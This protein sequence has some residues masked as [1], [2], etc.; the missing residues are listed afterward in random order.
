MQLKQTNTG[1]TII[2]ALCTILVISLIAAGVLMNSSARYNV[3]SKQVKG[4]KEA[5]YA[6][7]SGG[8]IAFAEVRKVLSSPGTAFSGWT[9]PASPAPTPGP[10]YGKGPYTFG[11]SNSLSTSV[12][13]DMFYTDSA[14]AKYY[15]IRSTGTAKLF[16]LPRT[17][18]DSAL[19]A[20]G[21]HF[22]ANSNTRGNGDTLL[23]K[24]DF[25]YDHFKATY[26]DG[27]GTN[28]AMQ[29]VSNPQ[30]TRR[31]EL[32]VGPQFAFTGALKATGTFAG[33]GSAGVVDSYDS[34]NGAYSFVANNPASPL[35][36]DSQNGDV[37]VGTSNFNQG[38]PIYGNV[39]TNGGNVTHANSTV[40]G[41]IDNNAP[42]TIPP[43]V[44]PDT[45]GYTSGAGGTLTLPAPT[46]ANGLVGTT[47]GNPA[48]YYYS[49]L[50]GGLTINGRTVPAG[51]GALSGKPVETWVKIVVGAAGAT[52]GDVGDITIAPGINVQIYYTG[53]FSSKGKDTNN[54]N[55]D[56]ATGVYT[57]AYN[58][59]GT[60]FNGGGT[61][62]ATGV[63]ASTD[64][65][66]AGHLQFYGISPTDGSS[67]T[68]SINPPGNMYASF[69]APNSNLSM[70]GNP[71]I[72]G[73]IVVHNFS[74]NGNTGFHYDKELSVLG[75][76]PIDYQLVSYVE[77]IR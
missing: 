41:T 69:Y 73:A 9:S 19:N 58:P 74:G 20:S 47:A 70:T 53:N 66:R 16:G 1:S 51:Q 40:S 38:G 35:Y 2:V 29:T 71:D 67:T 45:T 26:G 72:Y 54:N 6:A 12:T 64:Y 30:I 68:I 42:F 25:N 32:I 75:G 34:K 59:D 57:V 28:L 18:L 23:R 44:R 17:G 39:T 36:A 76:I 55:V 50:S 43:L 77:D 37:S 7:E 21:S 48:L 5:L 15:R 33:P 13:V 56:G 52:A 22:A 24:I 31:I 14:G 11:Q 49:S 61:T 60:I 10:S 3:A 65:S 4:W 46:T 27:D 62:P 63:Q 8:D